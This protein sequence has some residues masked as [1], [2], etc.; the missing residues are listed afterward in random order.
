MGV[1]HGSTNDTQ[2]CWMNE[3]SPVAALMVSKQVNGDS[4]TNAELKVSGYFRR[5]LSSF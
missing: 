2:N 5:E 4:L 1:S 3:T